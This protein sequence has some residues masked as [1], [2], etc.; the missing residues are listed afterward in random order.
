MTP[1]QEEPR[2]EPVRFT[3]KRRIDPQTGQVRTPAPAEPDSA[4][5][6]TADDQ[7]LGFHDA[8]P[9]AGE[10]AGLGEAAVQEPD[11][12][13]AELLERTADLQR[14]S[15]EYANYRRRVDRD[16][17]AVIDGAKSSVVAA[18]L[19]VLDDLDRARSH[20]DLEG[21]LKAV[22]DK[23]TEVLTAQGLTSF[24]AE[25]DAF[26][27]ALHEAVSHE[28]AGGEPVLSMVMRQGYRFGDRILRPAMVAVSEAPVSPVAETPVEASTAPAS[29]AAGEPVSETDQA[30][31]AQSHTPTQ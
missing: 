26:E 29:D 18:L 6:E 2:E 1:R 19:G 4:A 5:A 30:E 16:R 28:G 11:P 25:G 31:A 17:Q 14:L 24:G 10:E 7:V 22:A 15:A 12:L 9:T 8:E 13:Q 21:P 27:P 20:G 3:D 23:L